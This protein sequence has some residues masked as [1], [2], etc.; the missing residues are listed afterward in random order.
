MTLLWMSDVS[1]AVQYVIYQVNG[2]GH[3]AEDRE[4]G[5]CPACKVQGAVEVSASQY[6]IYR[7]Y[8]GEQDYTI[9]RPL[10]WPERHH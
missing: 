3:D 9:F 8:K 4:S 1:P 7:E 2:A 5:Q 10:P 6:L